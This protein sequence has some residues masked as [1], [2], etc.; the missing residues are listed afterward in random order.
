MNLYP[1]SP[2]FGIHKPK[3]ETI[4]HN[5]F[6]N[7]S[8]VDKD[9][10]LEK[11]SFNHYL[12][13]E[14][15]NFDHFYTSFGL[16][17]SE[18]FRDKE[19]LDLGCSY[20]GKS[21]SMAERWEVKSMSGI[22]VNKY[23]I[24]AANRFSSKRENGIS[25]NF[26]ESKG[27]NLPFDSNSFDYIISFDVF[28]HVQ[29]IQKTLV[30]CKRVLKPGGVLFAVF[31]SFYTPTEAHLTSATRVPCLQWFF[32]SK[33][34]QTAYDEIMEC[35][36]EKERYWYYRR[37]EAGYEWAKLGGGIGINGTTIDSFKEKTK[38]VGFSSINILKAPLFS[39]GH[40]SHKHLFF[41]KLAELVRPLTKINLTKDY[42]T[43]RIVTLIR[44]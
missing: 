17:L 26:L 22:D 13:E 41:K 3:N 5:D 2:Q 42:F 35:R 30:E 43:Q 24:R 10:I 4:R 29:S 11:I 37:G 6:I 27:E 1:S 32:K 33:D 7:L 9:R 25:F 34:I 38:L 16:N 40:F 14:Y 44:K 12:E 39:V 8:S 28:E 15:L 21:V 19:I 23:L 36:S 31:P 20:G 18:L